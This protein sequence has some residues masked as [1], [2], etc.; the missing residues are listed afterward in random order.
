[1]EAGFTVDIYFSTEF[2]FH[3]LVELCPEA[4]IL[5]LKFYH[6]CTA[7]HPCR[8]VTKTAKLGEQYMK[9]E[10]LVNSKT[11]LSWYGWCRK[12]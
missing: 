6:P 1:M 2:C 7:F 12:V 3:F 8:I 5:P 9:K 10:M 11:V 4:S